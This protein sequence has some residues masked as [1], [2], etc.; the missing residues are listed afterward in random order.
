MAKV[1]ST[2]ADPAAGLINAV[3]D[4]VDRGLEIGKVRSLFH[5][6]TV[7]TNAAITGN[8]AK[9]VLVA[10]EGYRDLLGYRTGARP[11]LYNLSQRKPNE[12]VRRRDRIEARE[13]LAWN[14]DVVEPLT[15]SEIE[16]IVAEVVRREPEAVAVAFLFSYMN[17]A[18]EV[19]VGEALRARLP[20]IP[21][22][23]SSEVAR[24]FR[25]YPRT[26][27][28][29]L[30]AGLRPVVG[31]YL[32]RAQESLREM[33]MS[34]PF[35]VIQSNGGSVPAERADREAHR[36][37]LS[38]PTAGVAALIELGTRCNIDKLVS[39]DMGGTSLDVC[40]VKDGLPPVT[41]MSWV[42][43]HPILAA[44]V[45]VIT[46]GAGGGSI[47]RSDVTGRLRVGPQSAG[48]DPGPAAYGR[49]G[50]EA[51]LTDAHVVV[52]TL[53]ASSNLAGRLSLDEG[54]SRAV[55]GRVADELQ[56]GVE[57]TASGIIAVAMAHVVGALRRV[58]VERGLDPSEYTVV[59][60]GG[61]GPLHAGLLLREMGLNNV[62]VPPH[63]GL[64]CASG[65]VVADLRVDE[66]QTVLRKL[67]ADVLG[68]LAAWYAEATDRLVD[69]LREDGISDPNMTIVAS[70]DCRY[71]GQGFELSVQLR[72]TS[73]QDLAFLAEDFNVLH[74]QSYGHAALDEDIEVVTLRLAGFGALPKLDTKE[75]ER[76]PETPDP[77]TQVGLRSVRLSLDAARV[78]VPVYDR[79]GLRYGN[80]VGGPAIIE[81]MDSTTLILAGQAASVDS[82]GNLWIGEDL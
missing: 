35:L 19:R 67:E 11:E 4:L 43:S 47:A 53:G 21:V 32:L 75:L 60:F 38:G 68:D 51:T 62:I 17:D 16:R 20:N 5:G 34:N 28:A 31:S 44:T 61:A 36:L 15:D 9:V 1:P 73:E 80:R 26:A 57:E 7:A 29:A 40:L 66:A 52:G 56:M 8:L 55:V 6:T 63:P 18:H 27:T 45:D 13:R 54:A 24:E 74:A 64:F 79:E 33:G 22:S 82:Y 48:A 37:L 23:I 41:P 2:P 70:A 49:G 81:E 72:G 30:N 59:C 50:T 14:G 46:V 65:L 10:T 12:L 71:L 76:G 42:E 69:R 25:E 78:Q 3:A 58:S 77:E 39:I